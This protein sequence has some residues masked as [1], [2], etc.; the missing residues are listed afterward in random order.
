MKSSAGADRGNSARRVWPDGVGRQSG[1]HQRLAATVPY[2][3]LLWLFSEDPGPHL[4]CHSDAPHQFRPLFLVRQN[5]SKPQSARTENPAKVNRL[6]SEFPM[7]RRI[8]LQ[9]HALCKIAN[10]LRTLITI[11]V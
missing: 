2:P 7:L 4:D 5:A 10:F 1:A 9:I 8:P 6:M 11:Y 3:K